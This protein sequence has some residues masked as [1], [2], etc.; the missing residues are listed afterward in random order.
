[1]KHWKVWIA[2]LLAVFMMAGCSNPGTETTTTT[3]AASTQPGVTEPFA[4]SELDKE[5]NDA[6]V[7]SP[8][9]DE[10]LAI[11]VG[12]ERISK[13]NFKF[14]VDLEVNMYQQ[15][16]GPNVL[17][18]KLN[19]VPF[20]D[21]I[22]DNVTRNL[23]YSFVIVSEARARGLTVSKGEVEKEY[24][25]FVGDLDDERKKFFT[26]TLGATGASLRDEIGRSLLIEKYMDSV[27]G[28][29][30]KSKELDEF[31]K[32]E[33]VQVKARHILV[34]TEEKAKELMAKL[35][36][37]DSFADLAA[38]HSNDAAN[39]DKG[40]DL[41]YFFHESMVQPFADKAFS[42]KP[43]E[44]GI[45]QTTYGF[46]IILVEDNRTIEKMEADETVADAEIQ[47]AKENLTKKLVRSR[48][49]KLIEEATPKYETELR[50]EKTN[51]EQKPQN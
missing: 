17:E 40:G 11:R 2:L 19:N 23:S 16:Y 32:N 14:Y 38:E 18:Q 1:M 39:K 6:Y 33:V 10:E 5:S 20:L 25:D 15:M 27:K 3:Q 44:K 46:H 36:A 9:T 51:Q 8:V 22:T 30:E 34:D 41:G 13:S 50:V 24:A 29:L 28:D 35:E 4:I 42:L 47:A 45:V 49:S 37:G 31:F 43:G 12:E 48:V 21:I 26:E 7:F